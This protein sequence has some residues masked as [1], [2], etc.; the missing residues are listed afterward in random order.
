MHMLTRR[1]QILLDEDRHR[2]LERRSAETGASIGALVREAIDVAFPEVRSD[3]ERS[4]RALL[5]ADP[6]PV[7]DWAELKEELASMHDP[8]AP[9]AMRRRTW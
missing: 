6:M 7:Q 8:P 2:R 1:T 4:A 5:S 3:R 9:S